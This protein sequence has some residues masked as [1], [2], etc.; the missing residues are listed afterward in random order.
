MNTINWIKVAPVVDF[1][2]NGGIAFLHNDLQIAIYNFTAKGEWYATQNKCPHKNEMAL[3]RGIIGDLAGEPKVA[4]PFHK[5][6]FSLHT[7]HCLGDDDLK[8]EVYPV[9]VENDIVY[10]GL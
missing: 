8:L 10:I 1:P 5:K 3:A 9:K 2:E 6:N 7:G 4:C